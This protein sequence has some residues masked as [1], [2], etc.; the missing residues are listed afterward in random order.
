MI[1]A[2]ARATNSSSYNNDAIV[3]GDVRSAPAAARGVSRSPTNPEVERPDPILA[4]AIACLL[5]VLRP[6]IRRD[7]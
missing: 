7:I 1:R 5:R 2:A 3:G 6:E 4:M